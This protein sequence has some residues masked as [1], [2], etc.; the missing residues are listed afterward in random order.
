MPGREYNLTLSFLVGSK[1]LSQNKQYNECGTACPKTCTRP[2]G[3]ACTKQCVSGCFCKE[4]FVLQ[5]KV[6]LTL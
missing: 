5:D 6:S 4:G 2:E 1:T 3:M